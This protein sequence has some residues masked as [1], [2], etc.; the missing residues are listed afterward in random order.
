LSRLC[1]CSC[2][3][4]WRL[5][6]PL[7]GEA[8]WLKAGKNPIRGEDELAFTPGGRREGEAVLEEEAQVHA[9]IHF[10]IRFRNSKRILIIKYSGFIYT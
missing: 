7:F 6:L 9:S 1:L 8:G 2:S 10:Q 5:Q 3:C 4:S